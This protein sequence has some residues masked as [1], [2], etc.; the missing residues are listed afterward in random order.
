MPSRVF[1]GL[2]AGF[3]KCVASSGSLGAPGLLILPK[4]RCYHHEGAPSNEIFARF[5]GKFTS[6]LSEFPRLEE[7]A[8]NNV[9]VSSC[10]FSSL[11]ETMRLKSLRMILRN[12]EELVTGFLRK[13]RSLTSLVLGAPSLALGCAYLWKTVSAFELKQLCLASNSRHRINIKAVRSGLPQL[14][15]RL[16]ILHLRMECEER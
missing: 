4:N 2:M 3:G 14:M 6:Y 16:D 13:C 12:G 5:L 11:E 7:L 8:L 9:V 10:F 15:K 1:I